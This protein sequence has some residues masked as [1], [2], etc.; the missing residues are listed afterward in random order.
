MNKLNN[1]FEDLMRINFYIVILAIGMW[2]INGGNNDY[3]AIHKVTIISV[4]TALTVTL[5][6][7]KA[8]IIAV[9]YS[10]GKWIVQTVNNKMR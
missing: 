8:L 10:I 6:L 7:L 5:L 3:G 9:L 4:F 1:I 2:T